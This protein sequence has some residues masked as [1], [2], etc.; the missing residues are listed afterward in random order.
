MHREL[1]IILREI[2]RERE[3]YKL[4]VLA[5]NHTWALGVYNSYKVV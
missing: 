5:S 2:L 1:Q 3:Q 4:G